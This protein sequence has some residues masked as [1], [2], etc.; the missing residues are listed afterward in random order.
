MKSFTQH[1]HIYIRYTIYIHCA[2]IHTL[3]RTPPAYTYLCIREFLTTHLHTHSYCGHIH[4]CIARGFFIHTFNQACHLHTHLY[5]ICVEPPHIHIY[6]KLHSTPH[7]LDSFT[8]T[9][10]LYG[11]SYNLPMRKAYSNTRMLL[12]PLVKYELSF[13]HTHLYCTYIASFHFYVCA[14]TLSHSHIH[15]THERVHC[16]LYILNHALCIAH[17]H[18][19]LVYQH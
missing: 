16:S 3:M 6:S 7:F 10:C 12:T 8:T 2:D 19:T 11:I 15:N 13:P 18:F 5:R 9:I 17:V 14:H 4:L 1:T